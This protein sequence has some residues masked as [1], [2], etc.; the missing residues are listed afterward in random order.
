M[1]ISDEML[2]AFVNGKLAPPERQ[3]VEMAIASDQKIARRVA[4]QRARVRAALDDILYQ[5][6]RPRTQPG[7]LYAVPARVIDL[8]QAR[9]ELA[10]RKP[11]RPAAPIA[12]WV[13]LAG[14]AGA[15]LFGAL[16]MALVGQDGLMRY[17]DG[18]L[19]ARGML[20][21]ALSAQL[22]GQAPLGAHI[23]LT[24]SYRTRTGAVCR[25]FSITASEV[26][27]GLACREHRQ[28]RVQSLSGVGS[29][30]TPMTAMHGTAISP[31]SNAAEIQLRAHDW[32]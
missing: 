6:P 19:I 31:L 32:Q 30:S 9:A 17:G 7:R 22:T 10:R 26:L 12:R 21:T 4:R 13:T 27:S 18:R 23:L 28:W 2:S 8:A 5:P 29:P 16:L 15:A 3:Q 24:A 20:D 1:K 25:T 11:R 14:L